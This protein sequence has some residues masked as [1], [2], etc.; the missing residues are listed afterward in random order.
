MYA[1]VIRLKQAFTAVVCWSLGTT[2]VFAGCMD[3]DNQFWIN[4]PGARPVYDKLM[5]LMT[6]PLDAD[7]VTARLIDQVACNVF[8]AKAL[9]NLYDVADFAPSNNNGA[10]LS[11]NAIVGFVRTHTD[12]WSKLG[13]ANEQSVLGNAAAG[14]AGG[15]PVIAAAEGDPHGH[16]ALVLAGQ[17]QTA[18]KAPWRD[19][20]GNQ[21]KVPNSAAFSLNDVNKAYVFCR[22]SAAFADPSL[23]EIYWRV[24]N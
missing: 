19:S 2:T 6:C 7:K 16:V 12:L 5:G 17:L 11:A 1:N 8:V 23:V 18:T 3:T 10:W 20:A 15:Q 24:K 9:S 4:N 21:L 13:L 22:L 14:A